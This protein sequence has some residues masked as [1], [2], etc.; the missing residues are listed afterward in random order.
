MRAIARAASD[1]RPMACRIWMSKSGWLRR[2]PWCGMH[3]W[4]RCAHAPLY[5][6]LGTGFCRGYPLPSPY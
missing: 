3:P 4:E 2:Q 6:V 5:A 1:Y